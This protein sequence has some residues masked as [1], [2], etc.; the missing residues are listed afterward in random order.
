MPRNHRQL[1]EALVQWADNAYIGHELDPGILPD[2]DTLMQLL[3]DARDALN[4][5]EKQPTTAA[6]IMAELFR[7]RDERRELAELDKDLG[8]QYRVLE[9]LMIAK[10]DEQGATRVSSALGTAVLTETTVP[11]VTDWDT[12]YQFIKDNDAFHF[13]QRRVAT[14]AFREAIE[15]K[16]EIPG[17]TPFSQRSIN[18]RAA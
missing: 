11:Q 14:A 9:A 4:P 18:L 7:I 12:F 5:Q 2:Q 6:E 15:A 3:R 13:L 8:H 17:L 16:Q 10:C 1:L